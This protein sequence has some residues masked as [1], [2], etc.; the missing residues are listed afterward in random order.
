[1]P[2]FFSRPEWFFYQDFFKAK[3]ILEKTKQ[4]EVDK[5]LK[6]KIEL[7]LLVLEVNQGTRFIDS[8][9]KEYLI[10]LLDRIKLLLPEAS[11]SVYVSALTAGAKIY[12]WLAKDADQPEKLI[13]QLLTSLSSVIQM[14]EKCHH[15]LDFQALQDLAACRFLFG[16][17]A[18]FCFKNSPY[19]DK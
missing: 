8:Y 10:T 7:Q 14:S 15:L 19:A 11:P 16:L 3:K 1:M 9:Q 18:S 4:L 13:K 17:Y 12:E 2:F 5:S 6:N